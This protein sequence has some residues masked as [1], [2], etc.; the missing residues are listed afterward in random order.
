MR[1]TWP[2]IR[3]IEDRRGRKDVSKK[4][5]KSRL[6]F[7]LEQK[8][9]FFAQLSVFASCPAS[10]SSWDRP[11]TK[12]RLSKW[13]GVELRVSLATRR[14]SKY[15]KI[16]AFYQDSKMSLGY[17][18]QQTLSLVTCQVTEKFTGVIVHC[19][20]SD[21]GAITAFDRSID[22][23]NPC[24]RLSSI[25]H[26]LLTESCYARMKSSKLSLNV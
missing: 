3:T 5:T 17:F 18:T 16:Q 11:Q 22:F 24:F 4:E 6:F 9:W 19:S 1:C 23:D 8:R 15:I 21:K 2:E 25:A 7:T 10:T 12:Q 26:R 13:C 20:S 14:N